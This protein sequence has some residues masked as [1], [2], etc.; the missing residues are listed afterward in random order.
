MK[1]P[2]LQVKLLRAIDGCGYTP[3]GGTDVIKP[4][5]RIIAATNKDLRDYVSKKMIR[6]DFFYRI[7]VL[8]VRLP[9][10]RE[11]KEDIPLLIDYFLSR[12]G[13]GGFAADMPAEYI[14]KMQLHNWPGNIRELRNTI[15]RYLTLNEIQFFNPL[16]DDSASPA[17]SDFQAGTPLRDLKSALEEFEGRYILQCLEINDWHQSKTAAYLKINRKTLYQKIQQHGIQRTYG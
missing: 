8:P 13:K 3:V 7:H 11:R 10:L 15:L 17:V 9:P 6:E 4:D 2:I 16:S 5:I 14:L 1:A 12:Y